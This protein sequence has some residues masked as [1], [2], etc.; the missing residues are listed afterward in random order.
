MPVEVAKNKKSAVLTCETCGKQATY[1]CSSP[2]APALTACEVAH[3]E[4]GW[5]F[6]IGFFSMLMGHHV[7]CPDCCDNSKER[8]DP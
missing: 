6:D 3:D 2:A 8:T 7:W 1:P 4:D 5:G